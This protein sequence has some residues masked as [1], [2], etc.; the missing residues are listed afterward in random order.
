[1]STKNVKIRLIYDWGI[2]ERELNLDLIIKYLKLNIRI[3]V[4][5]FCSLKS[6]LSINPLENAQQA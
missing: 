5:L 4:F 3:A 2:T 1:M 6:S